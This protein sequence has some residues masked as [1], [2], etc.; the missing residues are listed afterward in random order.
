MPNRGRIGRVRPN[1]GIRQS[2]RHATPHDNGRRHDQT[3]PCI[4]PLKVRPS[5]SDHDRSHDV[6]RHAPTVGRRRKTV[7]TGTDRHPGHP[8]DPFRPI[9]PAWF[10]QEVATTA[11]PG[12]QPSHKHARKKGPAAR[13]GLRVSKKGKGSGEASNAET[14]SLS[15]RRA[16]FGRLGLTLVQIGHGALRTRGRGKDETLIVGQ[17]V[18]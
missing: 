13:R 15:C 11:I 14:V 8:G 12:R 6:D 4:C 10:G 9:S 16:N 18:Q 7:E 5:P 1:D 2:D 3:D 17:H